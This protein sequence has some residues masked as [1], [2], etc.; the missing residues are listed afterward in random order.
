MGAPA[1]NVGAMHSAQ[2]TLVK[3]P[4]ELWAEISDVGQGFDAGR[5][6]GFGRSGMV[7]RAEI[8]HGT[9]EVIPIGLDGRG[10][11]IRLVVPA[12]HC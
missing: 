7:E 3:S 1:V 6:A 5:A 11:T 10:T 8:A 9:L 12:R 4:P 2:R